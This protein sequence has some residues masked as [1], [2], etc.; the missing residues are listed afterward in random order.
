MLRRQGPTGGPGGIAAWLSTSTH[1]Q[2]DLDSGAGEEA[3]ADEEVAY[4]VVEEDGTGGD[5]SA[6]ACASSGGVSAMGVATVSRT[7]RSVDRTAL[8]A[9]AVAKASFVPPPRDEIQWRFQG[10]CRELF[11]RVTVRL[12]DGAILKDQY[13]CR[14]CCAGPYTMSGV[15]VMKS[16]LESHGHVSQAS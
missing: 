14:V 6:A 5:A 11:L 12:K 8:N 7:V 4:N 9:N 2:P 16:H 15:S 13:L 10:D 3:R 1:Q